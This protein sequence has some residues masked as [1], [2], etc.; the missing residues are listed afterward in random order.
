MKLS[1]RGRYAI[2]FMIDVALNSEDDKPVHLK[3]I[4]QRQ[5][6]SRRYLEQIVISLK[7]SSLVRAVSGRSGG[8]TLSRRPAEV[9]IGEI[10]EAAIGPINIVECVLEPGVCANS[11]D[12]TCRKL[13]ALVNDRI[14]EAVDEFTLTDVA[15]ARFG[16]VFT[17]GS[18]CGGRRAVPDMCSTDFR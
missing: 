9:R 16:D 1:T 14:R 8:Y 13:Y 12:C 6:I 2:R 4:A 7:N 15:G 17:G 18:G 10:I 5:G 11:G 3:E